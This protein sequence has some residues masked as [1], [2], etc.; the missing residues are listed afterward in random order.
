MIIMYISRMLSGIV[1]GCLLS[2]VSL[3]QQYSASSPSAELAQLGDKFYLAQLRFD[4]V[5]NG[6]FIGDNRFDDKLNINITPAERT[7]QRVLLQRLQQQL[8]ALKREQFSSADA[9]T[10]DVLGYQL[11]SNLGILSYPDYLLPLEHM[12][13][14]PIVLA[15]FGSGQAEQPL[16]TVA[17]YD[18]YLLRIARLPLWIEQALINMRKG[19]S[20]GIVQPHPIVQAMLGP[21]KQLT[22]DV[23]D[24]PFYA[25]IKNMPT[26]FDEVSK[27]RLQQ[28][29]ADTVQNQ[30]IPAIKKLVQFVEIQYLPASRNTDGWSAMPDGLNWY[31]QWVKFQTTTDLEPDV[32]HNLGLQEV[33]RIHGE[34]AKLAPKLGYEGDPDS[35]LA[36]VRTNQKF[37]S[38]KSEAEILDAY[39]AINTRVKAQLPKLFGRV[40]KADLDIRPEPE[41][42]RE[43]AS[44]HYSI[45]A[46]DGSRPGVFWAVINDPTTYNSS[47][48]GSLF[49]HE[50]QPGH[51][52]HLALQQEL[53]LPIFRKRAQINAFAEGWA[54]YAETLGHE[55][56]LY[57]DPVMYAG[58]LRLEMMRAVRLVV[59]TGMHA[60]GWT[61]DQ[62][63]AYVM[64]NTG[65]SEVQARNQIERYMIWPGQ[66]LGY[67]IGALKI[68]Q[69]RERAKH[70]L[71][72]KFNIAAFHDAVLAEG[73]LPLS[74]LEARINHWIAQQQLH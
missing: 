37:L 29:Y 48:M 19:M 32:I 38:F 70:V 18:A 2:S 17:Q 66:A 65:Y 20:R 33:A 67:K 60:K 47:T 43:T 28:E 51:H 59:D 14:M 44:D 71:G 73:S 41:L 36:W 62:A 54:L 4:P 23:G 69:L 35:F 12:S 21:L 52:F 72:D 25:P 34:L 31:K 64:D 11:Q 8:H 7:H 3:A 24:N 16:K 10:Y 57:D 6:T 9:L 68:Q 49:L 30:I 50:G 53:N 15:N 5:A 58:N 1:L 27:Q 39:R 56:G 13:A 22:V 55:M 40:P 46:E 63:I 45:S 42:T 74:V 61:H 26:S